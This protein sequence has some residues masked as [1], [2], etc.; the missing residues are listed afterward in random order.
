M[1]QKSISNNVIFWQRRLYRRQIPIMSQLGRP[2]PLL[3]DH[4]D[5]IDAIFG[6]S[7][8]AFS[9]IIQREI[10]L[11]NLIKVNLKEPLVRG[12]RLVVDSVYFF[13]IL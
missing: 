8:Y 10:A 7:A 11:A 2:K 9:G 4:T 12:I 1:W 13:A 6:W 5:L 3:Y